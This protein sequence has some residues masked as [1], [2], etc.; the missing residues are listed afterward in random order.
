[1]LL[2]FYMSGFCILFYVLAVCTIVWCVINALS[3]YLDGDARSCL[4]YSMT[5]FVAVIWVMWVTVE[6]I[7]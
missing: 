7:L 1:M 2:L 5:T 6:V 3:T 4:L